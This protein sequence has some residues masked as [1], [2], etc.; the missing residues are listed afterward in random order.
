MNLQCALLDHKSSH[1]PKQLQEGPLTPNL[2]WAAHGPIYWICLILSNNYLLCQI[3]IC[4]SCLFSETGASIMG[5]EEPLTS[6]GICKKICMLHKS[7]ARFSIWQCICAEV[8]AIGIS[9]ICAWA[10]TH[11]LV[12]LGFE[13]EC[14]IHR[15][16][17]HVLYIDV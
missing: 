12:V 14:I 4:M 5:V 8:T 17:I 6:K 3:Q 11:Q 13:L 1:L 16:I 10:L 15:C 7:I 2:R 9:W